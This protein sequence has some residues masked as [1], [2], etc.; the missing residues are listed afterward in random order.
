MFSERKCVPRLGNVNLSSFLDRI[1]HP[2]LTRSGRLTQVYL[3]C[4]T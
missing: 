4:S 1:G 2:D 3:V